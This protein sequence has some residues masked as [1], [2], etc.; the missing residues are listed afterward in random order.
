[1]LPPRPALLQEGGAHPLSQW[2]C[3]SLLHFC[4]KNDNVRVRSCY[5]RLVISGTADP[6][7]PSTVAGGLGVTV[8]VRQQGRGV[9]AL[10]VYAGLKE[11]T[12][13]SART[14]G[15]TFLLLPCSRQFTFPSAQGLPGLT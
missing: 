8:E 5:C 11:G 15:V 1:M 9:H 4:N 6:P 3:P 10:E 13:G 2:Q 7:H 12:R 14:S